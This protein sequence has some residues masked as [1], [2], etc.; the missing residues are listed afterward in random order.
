MGFYP[1]GWL[2]YERVGDTLWK[3]KIKALEDTNL[4]GGGGES[5]GGVGGGEV[6]LYLTPKEGNQLPQPMK[7]SLLLSKGSIASPKKCEY[8]NH[9]VARFKLDTLTRGLNYRTNPFT[10]HYFQY[11]CS[12]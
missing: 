2:V 10:R 6:R 1:G 5:G 9:H 11:F 7:V 8:I 4:P 3:I 12:I